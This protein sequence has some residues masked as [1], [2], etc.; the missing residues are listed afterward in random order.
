[1][2][3]DFSCSKVEGH[4][5]QY[6]LKAQQQYKNHAA[7]ISISIVLYCHAAQTDHNIVSATGVAIRGKSLNTLGYVTVCYPTEDAPDKQHEMA[8]LGMSVDL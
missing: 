1:M 4:V 5:G 3:G 7:L 6:S 2:G 8:K